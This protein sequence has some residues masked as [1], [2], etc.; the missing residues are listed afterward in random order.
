MQH[1]VHELILRKKFLIIGL[2]RVIDGKDSFSMAT[3]LFL[4]K[5]P[6]F[7]KDVWLFLASVSAVH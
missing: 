3:A 6:G 2:P 1:A 4:E 5:M 7:W